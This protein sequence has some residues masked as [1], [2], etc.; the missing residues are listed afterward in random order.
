MRRSS[1]RSSD[2]VVRYGGE[3]FTVLL[4]ETA[5]MDAIKVANKIHSRLDETPILFEGQS[6]PALT[7]SIGM[8]GLLPGDT[9]A[10]LKQAADRALYQAKQS[11]RHCTCVAERHGSTFP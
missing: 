10:A 8:A 4:P 9:P 3:E 11:G 1:T 7:V 6:L 2:Y 5:V